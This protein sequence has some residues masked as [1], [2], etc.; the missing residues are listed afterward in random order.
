MPRLAAVAATVLLLLAAAAAG[1]RAVDAPS[2]LGTTITP[3]PAYK[4]LV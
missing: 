1:Q 3:D 2:A 4:P